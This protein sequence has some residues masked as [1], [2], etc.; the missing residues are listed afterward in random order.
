MSPRARIAA[1]TT[2]AFFGGFLFGWLLQVG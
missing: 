2:A 1:A